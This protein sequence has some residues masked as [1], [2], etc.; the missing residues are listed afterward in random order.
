MA[1]AYEGLSVSGYSQGPP[2]LVV[3][4]DEA[5]AQTWINDIRDQARAE[6]KLDPDTPT[7]AGEL[8][9]QVAGADLP[10]AINGVAILGGWHSRTVPGVVHHVHMRA[11]RLAC[12]C[13]GWFWRGECV[14][15]RLHR[16]GAGGGA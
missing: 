9:E 10:A 1:R 2:R 14:H 6:R 3:D 8:P 7:V 15:T 16:E 12:D 13:S 4:E 5:A 11:G